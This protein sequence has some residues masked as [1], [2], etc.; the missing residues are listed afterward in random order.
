MRAGGSSA[1]RRQQRRG[2]NPV[3][4]IGDDLAATSTSTVVVV[5]PLDPQRLRPAASCACANPPRGLVR[6][7]ADRRC[8]PPDTCPALDRRPLR[9]SV[10]IRFFHCEPRTD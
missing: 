9:P 4:R 5:A 6:R 8:T 10:A 1:R 3:R 7:A 2:R